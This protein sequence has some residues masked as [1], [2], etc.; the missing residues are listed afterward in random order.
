MPPFRFRRTKKKVEKTKFKFKPTERFLRPDPQH[1]NIV[2]AKFINQ[3]MYD[4]KKTVA[5]AVVYNALGIIKDR[6]KDKEPIEVV[7]TAINNVKPHLEVR[8]KRVGGATYQVP[9]EVSRKRQQ[10]LAIRQIL[11]NARGK[12]GKPMSL[13]LADELVDAFNNQGASITWREN[14]HKMAEANRL[15]AHFAW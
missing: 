2:L 5:Q 10:T 13:R 12:K 11:Q 9:M 6:V 1:N 7:T 8:S 15:F 4:G 14:T 3:L